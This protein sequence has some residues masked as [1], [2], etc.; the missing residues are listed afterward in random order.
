MDIQASGTE[1]V[2]FND[3]ETMFSGFSKDDFIELAHC[4]GDFM[5]AIDE[6]NIVRDVAVNGKE[7]LF[8]D[9]WIG[10]K[11]AE[12]VT[13]ESQPKIERMLD[14]RQGQ[15]KVWRQVNHP[16]DGNDI[17]VKYR[18]IRPT[19]GALDHS[20]RA[21]S[22]CYIDTATTAAENPAINGARLSES[23]PNRDS[24]PAAVR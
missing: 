14:S 22:A 5:L 2:P 23:A 3:A 12:T 17:P 21:R 20:S 11:W 7:Y 13:V 9:N 1:R 15:D 6:S 8:A 4:A 24:L 16:H 10:R 18:T 19:D